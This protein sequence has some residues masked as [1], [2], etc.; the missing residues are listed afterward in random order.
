MHEQ[1]PTSEQ[2]VLQ[3]RPDGLVPDDAQ[4]ELW[5]G[6]LAEQHNS[7]HYCLGVLTASVEGAAAAIDCGDPL[8]LTLHLRLGLAARKA[9]EQLGGAEQ[10]AGSA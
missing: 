4:V 1:Q 10:S 9:Y 5:R 2:V 8:S 7:V 3:L 6:Y